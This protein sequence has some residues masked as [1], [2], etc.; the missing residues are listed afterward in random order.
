[1]FRCDQYINKGTSLDEQSIISSITRLLFDVS[2]SNHIR[3]IAHDLQLVWAWLRSANS[4]G[5]CTWR[6]ND[7]IQ[8]ISPSISGIL[9]KPPTYHSLRMPYNWCNFD[10]DRSIKG[11]L[12]EAQRTFPLC[13]L[14]LFKV[15]FWNSIPIT[16]C[17]CATNGIILVAIAQYRKALYLT[18][19]VPYSL[20]LAFYMWDLS[21]TPH[22]SL[23]AHALQLVQVWLRSINN[24]GHFTG[25]TK[26]LHPYI[27]PSFRG[28]FLKPHIYHL[29][30][31]LY[32]WY[33]FCYDRS[34]LLRIV[35]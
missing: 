26:Y 21:E 11:T 15:S 30:C 19:K 32:N 12:L 2:S 10:C 1:M 5:H 3:L 7:L 27:L 17:S 4:E 28:I 25:I 29:L 9:L 24:E 34:I 23:T 20:Y 8:C 13:K 33:K 31:M 16:H 35:L 6:T 18:N 14:P 22:L